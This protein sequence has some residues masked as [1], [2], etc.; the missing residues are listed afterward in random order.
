MLID[1]CYRSV[2]YTSYIKTVLPIHG[3]SR[4]GD[5]D[6]LLRWDFDVRES[7]KEKVSSYTLET[8]N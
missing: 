8:E 3:K 5:N 4:S 6:E 2:H 1:R 7:Y